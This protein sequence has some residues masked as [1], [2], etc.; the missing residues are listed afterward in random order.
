MLKCFLFDAS[1]IASLPLYHCRFTT[2][3]SSLPLYH[4]RFITA[5]LSLPLYHC[6]FITAASSRHFVNGDK[7]LKKST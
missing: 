5:A 7:A 4:C 3:A 1:F 2:A 6:R